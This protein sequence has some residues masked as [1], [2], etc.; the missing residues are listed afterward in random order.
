MSDNEKSEVLGLV[1]KLEDH[2]VDNIDMAH[3]I[4]SFL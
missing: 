1:C 4:N 2:K 3:D